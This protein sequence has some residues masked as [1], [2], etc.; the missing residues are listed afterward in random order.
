MR[1]TLKSA[2]VELGL[3]AP[4]TAL[5]TAGEDEAIARVVGAYAGVFTVVDIGLAGWVQKARLAGAGPFDLVVD[6]GGGIR[7]DP[8]VRFRRTLRHLRNGGTYLVPAVGWTSRG[9]RSWQAL[10]AE[11]DRECRS[12]GEHTGRGPG[13]AASVGDVRVASRVLVV[14]RRGSS[15]VMMREREMN[16][17]LRVNPERGRTVLTHPGAELVSRCE[18]EVS[19]E[20]A[21]GFEITR[22][23][24]APSVHLREY[25]DVLCARAG[26]VAQRGLLTP[27]SFRHHQE[28]VLKHRRLM[29]DG[30]GFVREDTELWSDAVP[31]AGSYFHL[32]N[33]HPGHYGHVL[34]EQLSRVWALTEARRTHP[35]TR[36][37]AGAPRGGTLASWQ[38]TLLAAAG[39]DSTEI[40]LLRQRP[41]R[42]ER[43]LAA[44]PM[45]SMP[46]YAHPDLVSTWDA[47][48]E[49]LRE[50]AEPHPRPRR[51]FV[52]RG[53]VKRSCRN[54]AEVEDLFARH[55]F[56]I[57]RPEQHPL[58][59]QVAMFQDAEV[60]GGFAGSGLFTTLFAREPKHL[61]LLTP[62]SYRTNNEY[63]IASVRG[64]RLSV[65]VSRSEV[66]HPAIGGGSAE[67]FNSS[68][69]CDM[70]R[71]GRWLAG[72]LA[73][74]G[75]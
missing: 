34:S 63:L 29:A 15:L 21:A 56:Q 6:A 36:V 60:I 28:R 25:D 65:A 8:V 54:Q 59:E 75:P 51:I 67:A 44:T 42:V 39:I 19:P 40:T 3:T 26:L 4:R 5:L 31:L 35:E 66:D 62:T 17:A 38:L 23:F 46:K 49:R 32:D 64:H 41:R 47:V 9:G 16:E 55:G 69:T 30:N 68:F 61:V 12:V 18:V 20:H 37:L 71:E 45:F 33:E 58:P 53:R 2:L 7:G 43:L 72:V 57:I 70:T 48:G 50:L 1:H 11:L 73:D 22:S 10:R 74:L 24:T 27:D 13:I 14:V 52:T